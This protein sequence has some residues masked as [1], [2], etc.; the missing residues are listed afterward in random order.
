MCDVH[1]GVGLVLV[2][3]PRRAVHDEARAVDVGDHVGGL[4]LDRLERADRPAELDAVLRV[5]HADV[6]VHL[7][8]ADEVRALEH[9]RLALHLLQR[10]APPGMM[11]AFGTLH[12]LE[13]HLGLL[14]RGD[15]LEL[16]S[17]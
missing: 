5:L 9:R 14:V 16:A 7:R 4:V 3:R 1:V 6:E 15:R 17:G 8:Q 11:L 2:H 10:A 12:V 13:L